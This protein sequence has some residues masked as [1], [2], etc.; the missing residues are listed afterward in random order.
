MY[1]RYDY[2]VDYIMVTQPEHQKYIIN[3]INLFFGMRAYIIDTSY[4]CLNLKNDIINNLA[5]LFFESK[6]VEDKG[7]APCVLRKMDEAEIPVINQAASVLC[8]TVIQC[9]VEVV[10]PLDHGWC[11]IRSPHISST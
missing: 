1:K 2:D 11:K 9:I 8:K 10:N 5:P 4:I 6:V 3:Y 7:C